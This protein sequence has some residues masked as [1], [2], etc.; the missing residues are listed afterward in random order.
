MKTPY[1]TKTGI[2]IG[3]RYM[4]KG[5]VAPLDDRDMQLVQEALLA[6]PNYIKSKKRYELTMAISVS[7]LVFALLGSFLFS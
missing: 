2:K 1:T 6:T 3:S 4:E 5:Y 7:V